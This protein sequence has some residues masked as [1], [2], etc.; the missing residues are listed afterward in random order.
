MAG[1]FYDLNK[2]EPQDTLTFYYNG[3]TKPNTMRTVVVEEVCD[4]RI[5]AKDMGEVKCFLKKKII[6]SWFYRSARPVNY[7]SNVRPVYVQPKP[8]FSMTISQ[9]VKA[10]GIL[11]PNFSVSCFDSKF[12]FYEIN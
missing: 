8:K 12:N 9:V 2:L 7:V 4:D 11:H 5:F 3:G 10:L 6:S 1:P